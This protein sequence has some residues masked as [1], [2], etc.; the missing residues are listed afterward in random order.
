[1]RNLTMPGITLFALAMAACSRTPE[2]KTEERPSGEPAAWRELAPGGSRLA[3]LGTPATA[4]EVEA[5][6]ITVLPDGRGLP[7]GSGGVGQGVQIYAERCAACHGVDGEGQGDYP[8]LVGGRGTLGT[9]TPIQTIGS[10]WP[11]STTVFDYVHRAMPYNAPGSLTADETYAV[12]AFLLHRNGIVGADAVLGRDNLAAV[13]MPN[14]HGFVG[15][16]RPDIRQAGRPPKRG[17]RS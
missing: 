10:Y 7:P 8:K 12:T 11:Y 15:D 16:P 14:R 6:A 1:M 17:H 2:H 9:K 4:A 13:R 5:A 3:G